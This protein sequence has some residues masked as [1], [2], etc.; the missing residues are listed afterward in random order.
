[1]YNAIFAHRLISLLITLKNCIFVGNLFILSVT[2][3]TMQPQH[4]LLDSYIWR[5]FEYFFVQLFSAPTAEISKKLLNF[6][7]TKIVVF[8]NVKSPKYVNVLY[9]Y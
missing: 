9:K 6:S 4:M 3:N 2:Q 7:T 8:F 5:H 1:M